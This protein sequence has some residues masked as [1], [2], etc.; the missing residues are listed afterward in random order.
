MKYFDTFYLDL[1]K[2]IVI[3][4]Y[5]DKNNY[6]YILRTPNHSSGNLIRNLASICK[7][8]LSMGE[9]GLLQIRGKVPTYVNEENKH[10]HILKFNN[11]TVA[12]FLSIFKTLISAKVKLS[13]TVILGNKLKCW[14]TK[15]I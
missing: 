4:F 8:P 10:I 11:K 6:Y 9:D 3:D 1:E 15:P 7:L 12:S 5:L 2:D 13:I 14:K